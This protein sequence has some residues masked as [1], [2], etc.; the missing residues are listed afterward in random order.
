MPYI[1]LLILL[2]GMIPITIGSVIII[3]GIKYM[4]K[5]R[6]EKEDQMIEMYNEK[7]RNK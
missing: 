7:K 3:I 6:I 2:G 5:N 1:I 4:E